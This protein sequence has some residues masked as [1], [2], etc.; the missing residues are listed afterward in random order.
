ME[1]I[2]VGEHHL[3]AGVPQLGRRNAFHRGQGAHGH[4]PRCGDIAMGGVKAAAAGPGA[5]ALRRDVE[6]ERWWEADCAE[7][8]LFRR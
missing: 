6:G 5:A 2:G 4:E 8:V 1:V 7:Q 3:G